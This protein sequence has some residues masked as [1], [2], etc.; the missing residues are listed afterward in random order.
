MGEFGKQIVAVLVIVLFLPLL[1]AFLIQGKQQVSFTGKEEVETYLPMMLAQVVEED[2][3]KETLKAQAVLVRSNATKALHEG[4]LNFSDLQKEY[5]RNSR[6]Q[7]K[8]FLQFYETLA[9]AC[10]E[11][12]GEMVFYQ[13]Q[14]CYCPYF[15]VS[16]G[17][18]R[19]AFENFTESRYPYL[20]P[21]PS[22]RDEESANYESIYYYEKEE[23]YEKVRK[24][25]L[26]E[27][28]GADSGETISGESTALQGSETSV[29][30]SP[31][32]GEEAM[33]IAESGAKA[34]DSV[35]T[36]E[37]AMDIQILEQDSAGYVKWLRIDEQQVGGEAFRKQLGLA[38]ACFSIEISETQARIIC[39]GIGHGFGFSQY[40][41]NAMAIE[42]KNYRELIEYY[43]R[44]ITISKA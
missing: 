14:V 8:E 43:F 38:S 6:Y 33:D 28:R 15:A 3:D 39:K 25:L 42:G 12:E 19:D 21:V 36:G 22:H 41:A 2:L 31:E 27:N 32:T 17:I 40:G 35:G 20:M 37:E 7:D 44:D 30:D 11:T 5:L 10:R 34:M 4:N 24:L 26:V 16:S 13:N 9:A 23:F 1:L 18:T 29:M